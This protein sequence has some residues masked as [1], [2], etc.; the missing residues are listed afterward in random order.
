MIIV[1]EEIKYLDV[2]SDYLGIIIEMYT[3]NIEEYLR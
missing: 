3:Q 1:Y 2:L